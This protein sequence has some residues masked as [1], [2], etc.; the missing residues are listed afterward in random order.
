MDKVC[1]L[2]TKHQNA[3]KSVRLGLGIH[4]FPILIMIQL[5]SLIIK[6]KA[7]FFKWIL[8]AY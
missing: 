3:T 1:L 5:M 6:V 7:L 4:R 2:D 8:Y